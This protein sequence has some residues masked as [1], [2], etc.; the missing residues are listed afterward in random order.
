MYNP[1]QRSNDLWLLL[2]QHLVTIVCMIGENRKTLNQ[3]DNLYVSD[4]TVSVKE[5][6]KL[7]GKSYKY[8]SD[9]EIERLVTLLDNIARN[10]IQS[11]VP[12]I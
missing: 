12:Q 7:L 2:L 6:R 5:A 4:P 8:L 10:F 1:T 3:S 11:A 9:D